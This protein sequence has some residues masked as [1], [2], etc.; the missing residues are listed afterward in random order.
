MTNETNAENRFTFAL[1]KNPSNKDKRYF[2]AYS[3]SL[4]EMEDYNGD[5][6][7]EFLLEEFKSF[8]NQDFTL[9]D[10]VTC[11]ALCDISCSCGAYSPKGVGVPIADLLYKTTR[12][13]EK[14]PVA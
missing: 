6:L 7:R 3:I 9:T 5:G 12:L 8:I 2:L 11:W 1:P 10:M 4:Y 13:R 14:T